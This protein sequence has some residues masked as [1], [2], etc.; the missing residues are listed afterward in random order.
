[1]ANK[2]YGHFCTRKAEYTDSLHSTLFIATVFR[3]HV[4]LISS[5]GSLR[6]VQSILH[7]STTHCRMSNSTIIAY[8]LIS[9]AHVLGYRFNEIHHPKLV[10]TKLMG[11]PGSGVNFQV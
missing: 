11:G 1:M 10:H 5:I 3:C 7:T 2:S 8:L 9:L 4:F 6:I